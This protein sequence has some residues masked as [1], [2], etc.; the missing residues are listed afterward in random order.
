VN[1]SPSFA[2]QI[3]TCLL[4]FGV[5]KNRRVLTKVVGAAL[6][7][8]TL[9]STV[10]VVAKA[11]HNQPAAEIQVVAT[12][13][14]ASHDDHQHAPPATQGIASSSLLTELCVGIF[15]LVL[16]LGG[17]FLLKITQHRYKE[18][19]SSL[20]VGLIAFHRKHSFNLTLL[21]PQLG[22]YRI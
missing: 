14:H 9:V 15:Y 4:E 1:F 8:L 7:F 3:S 21:L 17:K 2:G 13:V 12:A 11:C 22:I 10:V 19:V 5:V 6:I 20:K 18:K 16:L